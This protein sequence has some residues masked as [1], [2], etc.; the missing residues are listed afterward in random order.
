[1]KRQQQVL[2]PREKE[3]GN[4]DLHMGWLKH[5]ATLFLEWQQSW[6]KTEPEEICSDLHCACRG[7]CTVAST[8]DSV[9]ARPVRFQ[10][11]F[12]RLSQGCFESGEPLL[13]PSDRNSY[14]NLHNLI[15]FGPVL[16]KNRFLYKPV[17]GGSAGFSS[18]PLSPKFLF[19]LSCCKKKGTLLTTC[20]TALWYD[21]IIS[22]QLLIFVLAFLNPKHNG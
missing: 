6:T 1:M 11:F 22:Q 13:Q 14:G 4:K 18:L 9:Q 3:L 21:Q 19:N 20:S 2:I 17:E 8:G 7:L 10:M 16:R 12:I 15:S 5:Q